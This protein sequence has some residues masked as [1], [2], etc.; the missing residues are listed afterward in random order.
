MP[1]L[2]RPLSFL[3]RFYAV[4][5]TIVPSACSFILNCPARVLLTLNLYQALTL[6]VQSGSPIKNYSIPYLFNHN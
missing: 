3:V 6:F 1:Y 5:S 4:P 2:V